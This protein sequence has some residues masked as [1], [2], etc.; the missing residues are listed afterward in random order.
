MDNKEIKI[1]AGFLEAGLDME[2]KMSKSVYGEYLDRKAWSENM[3]DSA[4]ELIKERL[5]ILI[6]ETENHK[7]IFLN[8]KNNLTSDV[9]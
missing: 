4:Y 1:V 8:L 5:L 7:K 2:D 6:Q 9:K 3:E